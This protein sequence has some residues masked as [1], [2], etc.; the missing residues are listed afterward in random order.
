[1]D[2]MA[3]MTRSELALNRRL[4]GQLTELGFAV[5]AVPPE[6]GITTRANWKPPLLQRSF[7]AALR[8][9]PADEG[10]PSEP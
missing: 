9:T 3:L 4:G 5:D 2:R 1:S 7:L 6:I 8:A 10:L